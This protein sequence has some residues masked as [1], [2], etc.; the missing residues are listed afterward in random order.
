MQDL[1]K[2]TV[3]EGWTLDADRVLG[4]QAL[5]TTGGPVRYMAT[6]D[7]TNRGFRSGCAYSGKFVGDD[8]VKKKTRKK[9]A[10]RG[11]AQALVDDAVAHLRE[12][13]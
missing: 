6:I 9:Y 11:W 2:L 3:P 5:L 4:D 12:V 8:W 7:F 1:T 10:G 13:L